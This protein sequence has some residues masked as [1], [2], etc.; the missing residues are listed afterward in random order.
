MRQLQRC[1][2]AMVELVAAIVVSTDSMPCSSTNIALGIAMLCAQSIGI[3]LRMARHR[4]HVSMQS[5]C[6][7]KGKMH[8]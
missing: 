6:F 5:A 4:Q 2:D 7:K 8:A 3:E 1:T